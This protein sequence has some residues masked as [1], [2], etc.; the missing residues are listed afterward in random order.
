[1]KTN[2]FC[3][4]IHG[5]HI[6]FPVHYTKTN[7]GGTLLGQW[8]L[9]KSSV[10]QI[11]IKNIQVQWHPDLT[12]YQGTGKV[13]SLYWRFV[14]NPDITNLWKIDQNPPLYRGWLNN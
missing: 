11:T 4:T 8:P 2:T 7:P 13:S 6:Y 3:R 10:L 1:M 5:I 9:S 12:K 14:P